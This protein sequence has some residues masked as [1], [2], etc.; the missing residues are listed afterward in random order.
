MVDD[1][2]GAVVLLSLVLGVLGMLS[3]P[4]FRP[5]ISTVTTVML[6]ASVLVPILSL[7]SELV[8]LPNFS[9][10]LPSSPSVSEYT[11]EEYLAALTDYIA[12]EL[13]VT[14]DA[15]SVIGEGFDL[16]TLRFRSVTVTL[17]G[18]AVFADTTA[19]RELL[20]ASFVADGGSARVLLDFG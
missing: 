14:A 6:V 3:H 17:S 13:D 4:R 7:I 19:L 1:I 8:S 9:P 2:F 15:V 11:E 20:L 5:M 12:D 10:I 18:G 16:S